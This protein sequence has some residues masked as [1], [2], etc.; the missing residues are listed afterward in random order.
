MRDSQVFACLFNETPLHRLVKT[1]IE[2]CEVIRMDEPLSKLR[3]VLQWIH[4]GIGKYG[5]D[6]FLVVPSS[7]DYS[8]ATPCCIQLDIFR[9]SMTSGH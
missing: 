8:W 3:E 2:G 5:T 1:H 4:G 9:L 7:T 6:H